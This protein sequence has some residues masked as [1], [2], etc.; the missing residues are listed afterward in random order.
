MGYLML[1][2]WI[3]HE[4][5]L[6]KKE[7]KLYANVFFYKT[8]TKTKVYYTFYVNRIKFILLYSIWNYIE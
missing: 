4:C 3:T 1:K 8:E 2:P 6:I 7:K 5:F